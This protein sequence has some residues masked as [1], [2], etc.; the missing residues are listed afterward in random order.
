MKDVTYIIKDTGRNKDMVP[1]LGRKMGEMCFSSL[2]IFPFFMQATTTVIQLSLLHELVYQF[3]I[4]GV[5]LCSK[6]VPADLQDSK[7][8]VIS[9]KY[10]NVN[11]IIILLSGFSLYVY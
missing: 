9:G 8:A 10:L 11:L 7:L 3:Y 5:F 2:T 6:L 1:S 4:A